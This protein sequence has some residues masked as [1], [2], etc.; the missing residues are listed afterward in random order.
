MSAARFVKADDSHPAELTIDQIA[1]GVSNYYHRFD[2]LKGLYIKYSMTS[3]N[4]YPK[5]LIA[6]AWNNVHGEYKIKASKSYY[7]VVG[8]P[9]V[10]NL[11]KLN[12]EFTWDNTLSS[13]IENSSLY[14]IDKSIQYRHAIYS[15]LL[16]AM[17]VAREVD[18][19]NECA[20][21][22]LKVVTEDYVLPTALSTNR[23]RYRVF[24]SKEFQDGSW[25]V[26]VE[27]AGYDK[28]WIDTDHGFCIKRREYRYQPSGMMR[29]IFKYL[30]H[31]EISDHFFFPMEIRH[32][33]YEPPDAESNAG[34][35]S[36]HFV[37]KINDAHVQDF[38]DTVFQLL[39]PPNN[40]AVYDGRN[41]T[42]YIYHEDK[43]STLERAIADARVA[44]SQNT[45][46]GVFIKASVAVMLIL[47]MLLGIRKLL[48]K[49][50]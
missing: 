45:P 16:R 1:D 39:K 14:S 3:E 13:C 10:R 24:E 26:V 38:D 12:S 41:D 34:K 5:S 30:D 6:F 44:M 46:W 42:R 25:C 23:N 40:A 47:S 33:L 4:I 48:R 9:V 37:F 21:M 2:A 35:V 43:R 15:F 27:R 31:R 20:P 11:R 29:E 17:C 32:D 28:I 50:A 22:R 49:K 36:V 19:Y 8:D 18:I 7:R